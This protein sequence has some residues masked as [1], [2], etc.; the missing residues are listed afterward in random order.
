MFLIL[1]A[2][3]LTVPTAIVTK[4]DRTHAKVMENM[5][6]VSSGA[7]WHLEPFVDSLY[8]N[9]TCILSVF[10]S[11]SSPLDAGHVVAVLPIL[12]QA[13]VWPG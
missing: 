11:P 12:G 4:Q 3:I 7:G 9:R 6:D 8:L 10:L 5:K 1:L 2:H 13:E